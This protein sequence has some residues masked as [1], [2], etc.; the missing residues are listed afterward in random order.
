[1][2][3]QPPSCRATLLALGFDPELHRLVQK[4]GARFPGLLVIDAE[5]K[6]VRFIPRRW[7]TNLCA[8]EAFQR[9]W[10]ALLAGEEAELAMLQESGACPTCAEHDAAED[11]GAA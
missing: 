2:E 1:M 8:D 6:P 5:D 9:E 4:A 10:Q 11:G 7:F 3:R